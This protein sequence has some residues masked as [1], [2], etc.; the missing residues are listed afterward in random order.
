MNTST[1][2]LLDTN[3]L[4][5]DSKEDLNH[6]QKAPSKPKKSLTPKQQKYADAIDS[7]LDIIFYYEDD[8]YES[9]MEESA[10]SDLTDFFE[11]SIEEAHS[12][13]ATA[14]EI[15]EYRHCSGFYN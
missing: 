13:L 4:A 8:D 1:S 9:L 3:D 6:H 12:M 5:K 11:Y 15:H 14:L 7:V 10:I 2:I